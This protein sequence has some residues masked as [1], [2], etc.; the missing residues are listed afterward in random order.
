MRHSISLTI[1]KKLYSESAGMCNLCKAKVNEINEISHIIACSPNGPRG[2]AE[3]SVEF[4][5]SYENLILL[6]PI[7]HRKVDGNPIGFPANYLI[8]KKQEHIDFINSRFD[9]QSTHRVSDIFCI[10]AFIEYGEL[11]KWVR[12][13]NHL[14]DQF[15]TN[16]LNLSYFIENLLLDCPSALPFNDYR[17]DK[18]WNELHD[19]HHQLFNLLIG[20]GEAKF[21]DNSNLQKQPHFVGV[22]TIGMQNI[23]RLNTSYLS[24]VTL[25]NLNISLEEKKNL[26]LEKYNNFIQFIKQNYPEINFL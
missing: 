10:R 6:C 19:S 11:N 5:N 24:Y 16:F 7:C 25:E 15:D 4:I 22:N 12:Y 3:Y 2:N 23:A 1:Q 9:T 13:I 14:P 8:N 21:I 20:Y 26:F 18:L 17:L